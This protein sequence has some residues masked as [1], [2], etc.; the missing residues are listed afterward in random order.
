MD[1]FAA[2]WMISTPGSMT[3][4]IACGATVAIDHDTGIFIFHIVP[5]DNIHI[6]KQSLIG[7]GCLI[8]DS[9]MHEIPLGSQPGARSERAFI[10]AQSTILKGVTVGDGAVVGND[11]AVSKAIPAHCLAAGNPTKVLSQFR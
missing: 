2:N 4:H 3:I 10:G 1:E 8:C 7:G 11:S 6:G 9:D 5:H